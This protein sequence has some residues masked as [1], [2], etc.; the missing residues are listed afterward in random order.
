VRPGVV[1]EVLP[2]PELIIKQFCFID[3]NTIEHSIELV[4]IDPVASFDL[5]IETR[6]PRL[7]IDMSDPLV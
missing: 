4:V 2:F 5:A 1:I 7:N 3:N 6:S